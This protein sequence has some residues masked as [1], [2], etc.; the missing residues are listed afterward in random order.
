MLAD[1]INVDETA[2]RDSRRSI[3]VFATKPLSPT[4]VPT[5]FIAR[6]FQRARR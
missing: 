4:S 1:K 3:T 6:L 2:E 5:I